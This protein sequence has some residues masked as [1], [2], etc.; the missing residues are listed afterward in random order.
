[1]HAIAIDVAHGSDDHIAAVVAD[2]TD[3]QLGRLRAIRVRF[4]TID[5]AAARA[6]AHVLEMARI[7][8]LDLA[9]SELA[10][11]AVRLL[12]PAVAASEALR[13]LV[14]L[15]TVNGGYL[16]PPPSVT[17]FFVGGCALETG[18]LLAPRH[19]PQ[20][21]TLGIIGVDD[22]QH[23]AAVIKFV[24][25]AYTLET[26]HLAGIRMRESEAREL[27]TALQNARLLHM[28]DISGRPPYGGLFP[29]PPIELMATA[30]LLHVAVRVVRGQRAL[31]VV[32]AAG[33]VE[34]VKAVLEVAPPVVPVFIVAAPVNE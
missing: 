26:L 17:E 14:L 8:M 21:K 31:H 2:M 25:Q 20:I 3:A 27:G 19:A 34:G 13:G 4:S 23:L 12:A 28:L 29:A 24:A 7:E 11:A 6:L 9:H 10:E 33:N 1:M 32:T 15:G 18:K 16:T 22:K 5:E 30:A